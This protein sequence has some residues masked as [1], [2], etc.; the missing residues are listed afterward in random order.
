MNLWDSY[1]KTVRS[2]LYVPDEAGRQEGVA[3][4][5][6]RLF[7]YMALYMVPLSFL[8]L[9][10]GVF[11]SLISDV[12][13]LAVVDLVAMVLLAF[14]A[15]GKGMAL[16]TRKLIFIGIFYVLSVVLLIY[17]GSFGPGLLY[18]FAI[19]VFVTLIY[20]VRMGYITVAVNLCLC[21][22]FGV[23]IHFR[24]IHS[25]LVE[26]YDI[27]SWIAVSSNEIFLSTVS[28]LSLHLLLHGLQSTIEN[29]NKLQRELLSERKALQD[30]L[31][32]VRRKNLELE[33]FTYFA[34]HDLQEPLT[35]IISLTDLQQNAETKDFLTQTEYFEYV[36][37]ASKRMRQLI[38][39]LL[40]YS[41]IGRS[42]V[43]KSMV[44]FDLLLADVLAD[45]Q[46]RIE[47][48]GAEISIDKLPQLLVFPLE[49]RQLFQNL[50]GNA[51][52]FSR[53]G[54]APVV[55]VTAREEESHWLFKV[56]DNG[57]GISETA[58]EKI[59]I[60]FQRLHGRSAYEGTG[61]GLAYCKKIVEL[62]GGRIWVES[63][64]GQGSTFCF[65]ISKETTS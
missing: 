44:D 3:F 42:S 29:E 1:K 56:S 8:A 41:R 65:T 18:L 19:T 28:V 2:R 58:F 45:M 6:D 64:V 57:I 24:L 62:H 46:V 16:A 17:L 63:A 50:I 14:L 25:P 33:Q 23:L 27:G 43:E 11:M 61:I 40:E 4:W 54:T 5:R 31:S 21:A 37:R 39:G 52:K 12:P 53:E 7:Y 49:M 48:A 60:I 9:V 22:A 10:P 13:L 38:H 59:F 51:I 32:E 47:Q 36:D 34:S 35:T 55:T 30:A 15:L 26:A 20:S